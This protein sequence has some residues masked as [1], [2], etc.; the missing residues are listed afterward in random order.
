MVYSATAAWAPIARQWFGTGLIG[1]LITFSDFV[2][3]MHTMLRVGHWWLGWLYAIASLGMDGSP[4]LLVG[5]IYRSA[6]RIP[7][8]L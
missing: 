2:D 3:E 5:R 6:S 7:I 4:V 1:G 8:I